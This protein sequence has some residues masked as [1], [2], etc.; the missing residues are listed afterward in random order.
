MAY[1]QIPQDIVPRPESTGALIV[2]D[3]FQRRW[4]NDQLSI[5]T[6]II[7]SAASRVPG[8]PTRAKIRSFPKNRRQSCDTRVPRDS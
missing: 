6:S 7:S 2:P 8:E 1:T 3:I 5:P 4:L